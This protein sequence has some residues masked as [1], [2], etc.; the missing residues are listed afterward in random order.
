MKKL[1]LFVIVFVFA[2]SSINTFSQ[3]DEMKKWMEYMTP[4]DMHKSMAKCVG[5]WKTHNKMWMDPNTPATEVDG[6]STGEMI[7]GDRYLVMKHKS[8][9]MGMPFEG[10]SIDGYDNA[11]KVFNSIWIDNMGTG[12]M[13][14]NGKWNESTK[15]IDYSGQ[16]VDPMTGGMTDIRST[17]K[18]ND[19]GS[20]YMEMFGK[21]KSGKEFKWMEMTMTK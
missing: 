9:M 17:M 1:I 12:I 10:M 7:L 14:M 6:T 3:D 20:M 21:D 2:F 15:T 4:G 8:T 13:Y 18:T 16:M 11:T 5:T 19:D